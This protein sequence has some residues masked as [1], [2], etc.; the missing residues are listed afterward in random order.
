MKISY[1]ILWVDDEPRPTLGM[2]RE[3]IEDFLEEFGIRADI[4]TNRDKF[5]G[6]IN[7]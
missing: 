5:R 3:G 6:S 7:S 4:S 1:K 2:I